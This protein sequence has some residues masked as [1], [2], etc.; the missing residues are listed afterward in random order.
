[1]RQHAGPARRGR[2]V[3]PL[4]RRRRT[5]AFHP[6]DFAFQDLLLIQAGLATRV[7]LACLRASRHYARG[8]HVAHFQ[9]MRAPTHSV[10][11]AVLPVRT[12]LLKVQK[13]RR[14]PVVIVQ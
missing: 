1:M 14:P 7:V 6:R 13:R 11:V 5:R 10:P 2:I 4:V 12:V 3:Q 9:R 8:A